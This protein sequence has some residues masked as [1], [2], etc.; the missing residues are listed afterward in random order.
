[1]HAEAEL[2]LDGVHIGLLVVEKPAA[3]TH[4]TPLRFGDRR[5][6]DIV[7]RRLLRGHPLGDRCQQRLLLVQTLYLPDAKADEDQEGGHRP[8]RH[9]EK[10]PKS[11]HGT[12]LARGP[13][14]LDAGNEGYS[15]RISSPSLW[16]QRTCERN[17]MPRRF[18]DS[19]SSR[20]TK[21]FTSRTVTSPTSTLPSSTRAA[22][23]SPLA[24]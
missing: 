18:A 8:K 23:P 24:V 6:Q 17:D 4:V 1:M 14:R 16:D 9:A 22:V 15:S 12:I 10:R 7:E 13:L 21:A 5:A 20:R 11:D 3:R 19:A 2:G